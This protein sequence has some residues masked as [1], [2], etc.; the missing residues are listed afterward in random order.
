M[1]DHERR[2]DEHGVR[3]KGKMEEEVKLP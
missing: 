1:K 3:A 2:E